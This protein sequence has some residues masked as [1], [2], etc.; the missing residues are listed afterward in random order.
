MP[1]LSAKLAKA[2]L[3][4]PLL[5]LPIYSGKVSAGQS[6]FPSPAQD[7]EQEELDL[8]TRFITNPPAT[9][10]FVVSGDS[11]SGVGIYDGSHLIV[12]RAITPKSSQIVVAVLEGELMVKRLYRRGATVKLLSENPA[13]PPVVLAEG[14]ELIIWG[15]V[16]YVISQAL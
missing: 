4:P 10:L 12:N 2:S 1:L 9:F 14:Q 16:T 8:N 3:N 5:C 15:V 7:Y 11:M 13:H 6:R